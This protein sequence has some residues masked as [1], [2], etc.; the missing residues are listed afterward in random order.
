MA[1]PLSGRM[2]TTRVFINGITSGLYVHVGNAVNNKPVDGVLPPV[3][4]C[5]GFILRTHRASFP[6]WI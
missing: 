6:G 1:S 3:D 5:P 4:P 2:G